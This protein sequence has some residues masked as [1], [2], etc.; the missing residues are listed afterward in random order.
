MVT[1]K[2]IAKRRYKK[3][4]V[5]RG[6]SNRRLYKYVR[7]ISR[8]VAGEVNKFEHT[9]AEFGQSVATW[10]AS[11]SRVSVAAPTYNLQVITSGVPYIYPINWI[12]TPILTE[13]YFDNSGGGLYDLDN[14]E[15]IGPNQ[16]S[17]RTLQFKQPAY[18]KIKD[19]DTTSGITQ[20]N[21]STD[22]TQLQYRLAYIYIN[23]ILR[24]QNDT[25]SEIANQNTTGCVRFVIVKDKQPQDQGATWFNVNDQKR[26]V[27][28]S[29]NINAQ[30]NQY[31]LGRFTILYDKKKYFSAIQPYKMFKFFKK[32]STKIRNSTS[33]VSQPIVQQQFISTNATHNIIQGFPVEQTANCPV[34]RNAYYLMIFSD[35][36]TFTYTN[37]SATDDGQFTLFSRT[38]YYNN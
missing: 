16:T 9:P 19:Y 8:R 20:N 5:K 37:D 28:N 26:S 23:M 15:I 31:S 1:K 35:G 3:R 13:T 27:F 10:Q 14:N 4:Y 12:Y 32:M 25:T 29:N 33:T 34:Q 21:V 38:A 7:S 22:G 11:T 36:L 6:S 17:T 18:Y 30:L 2:R 24:A